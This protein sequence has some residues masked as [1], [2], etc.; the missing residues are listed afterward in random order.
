MTARRAGLVLG[1]AGCGGVDHTRPPGVMVVVQEQQ[2]AWIRNFNPFLP[3]GGARWPAN[4]GVHE[5]L[6]IYN[7]MNGQY[8]PWLAETH[9]W[10]EAARV[11]VFTLRGG[12]RFSDGEAL[13]AEDVA[14][15][16]QLLRD[17]P[18]LDTGGA[19]KNLASVEADGERTVR[20]TFARAFAPGLL[21]VA[22][23]PIVPEHVWSQVEDPVA[24]ANPDPVGS[25]P[26]TE[27]L[28]FE[29]QL[30]ELGRNP[31]YWQGEPGVAVMRFP[32]FSSNDQINLALVQGDIDW[33]GTFV[34]AVE[35]TF[36]ARD[37]EHHDAWFPVVGDTVFLYPN[38]TVPPMDDPAVRKALS[39][40]I[41]REMVVKVAMYDYTVP[42]H[43][44][45]LSEGYGA[46]R[47]D[48]LAPGSGWVRHDP[49]A[50]AA[51][52]DAAGWAAG[53]DG[54]RR[55]AA[56][57][58]LRLEITTPAGW[59]DWVRAAQVIRRDLEAVGID[60]RVQGYDFSAW[61]DRVARGEFAL[62][63]GWS[64]AG[65]TPYRFYRA[66]M[67]TEGVKPVGEPAAVNWHRHASPR[68]DALFAAFEATTDPAEQRALAH[69]MQRAFLDE[70]PA[71][72]LFPSASWGEAN[73][74]WVTG[75]PSED[76]PYARLSPNH[77]PEHLLVMPRLRAR[78]PAEAP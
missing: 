24:F 39:L 63:L 67:A 77:G 49:A 23:V 12:L 9:A 4:A 58:P 29:T 22:H 51:L 78:R 60:A 46:W 42:A 73:T 71:I 36:E 52:L 32:T 25:G 61:F 27:V 45:G 37:P 66:L 34:P 76:E 38:A 44:T 69:D 74:T 55:D 53:P 65:P 3:V 75:F 62:T 43:P 47:L 31:H 16:F 15:T 11:L 28:R 18:A 33:A 56:G 40:A 41:D 5:P 21:E 19:W 8:T 54:V 50:A 20:V 17:H 2:A 70:A 35:R 64:Q 13:T 57:E 59:S 72:P 68:A 10:E 26:F 1:L 6:L 30:F 14:F 7:P 48:D